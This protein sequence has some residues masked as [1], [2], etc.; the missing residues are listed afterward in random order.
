LPHAK[1]LLE[2][3]RV[4]SGN[5]AQSVPRQEGIFLKAA[6]SVALTPP[7]DTLNGA[8]AISLVKMPRYYQYVF[9]LYIVFL[10]YPMIM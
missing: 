5:A 2:R 4:G 7:S 6:R 10:P 9:D 3:V 1:D 8:D